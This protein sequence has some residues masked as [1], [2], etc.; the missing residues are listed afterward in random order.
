MDPMTAETCPS[1]SGQPVEGAKFIIV[2]IRAI[3]FSDDVVAFPLIESLLNDYE[4]GLESTGECTYNDDASGNAPWQSGGKLFPR[5]P[6]QGWE[7][8]G[9]LTTFE[10][11]TAILFA[12]FRE[13]ENDDICDAKWQLERP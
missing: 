3:N 7:L 2:E 6:W 10:T 11:S 5:I 13:F 9:V 12:S 8:V 4:T 1:D